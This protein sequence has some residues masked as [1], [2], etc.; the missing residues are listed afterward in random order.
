MTARR[1]SRIL[2]YLLPLLGLAGACRSAPRPPPADAGTWDAFVDRYL[3]A[4]FAANPGFAVYQGRHEY[5]GKL[6][7]WSDAGLRREAARLRAAHDSA[8]AWDTTGLDARRRLQRRYLM[9][10]LEGQLFWLD[11]A[12]WPWKNPTWYAGNL[13]PNVY[14]ARPYANP[15]VRA[16][17]LTAWARAVPGAAREIQANLHTPL[18]KS[19]V[20]IGRIR[21]GGLVS[22]LRTDAPKAFTEVKDSAVLGG[23]H[24]ALGSAADALAQLD[25]WFASQQRTAI[26]SFAMGPELFAWM[27]K[28]TDRVEVPLDRLEALGRADLKRNLAALEK[29]CEA[30]APRQ[31]LRGCVAQANALK[32]KGSVVEA[33]RL[34]LDSLSAFVRAHDLV[35]V[36][37]NEKAEVHESPPYQ[38]WNFAYID[39]PGPYDKGLPSVYYVAPPDPSWTPAERADYLP[40]RADLEFTSVHEVWPGHFL[41]FLHSN[42][43]ADKFGAVFV[44]YAFAE[45]WA[46]YAEEMMWEA[47]LGEGSPEVHIGQLQNAL[48]RDARY[49]SAL[50]MQTRG[51]TP[52]QSERLFRE[53]ALQDAATARQQAA[54]GTFDPEYLNYTLGKLM[55]RQ[56]REDWTAS[57]GGRGAW[58]AFHDQFLSYGGP[59]V[60]LIREEML[61][62]EAGPALR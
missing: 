62:R 27:L 22:F 13:D 34:Q 31:T 10:V 56:L 20:A 37:G 55:I 48:L 6:P 29:A 44:T 47:G 41:Q 46:H 7:D 50:G 30:F 33:A 28:A 16:R 14:I 39:P 24:S 21:F 15:T 11:D 3:E 53:E 54:R 61:G 36:P 4:H 8:A 49:L 57:R 19:Y 40:G 51:T 35:T 38:R 5:D 23:L 25:A 52:A 42:R 1:G 60:P 26:D 45:G 32:P 43:S 18:P 58:K 59:P 17:A 12:R 9:A 2:R